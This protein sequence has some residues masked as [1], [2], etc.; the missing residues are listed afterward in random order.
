MNVVTFRLHDSEVLDVIDS[1]DAYSRIWMGQFD[2][3]D[4]TLRMW[5]FTTCAQDRESRACEELLMGMRALFLP[6]AAVLGRGA[7]LGIWSDEVNELAVCAY[8]MQQVIRHDWSW[9]NKPEGDWMSRW[10]D[11][12]FLH[13]SLPV[14]STKCCTDEDGSSAMQL[15]I[16]ASSLRLLLDALLAYD[17]LFNLR[18]VAMMQLYTRDDRVLAIAQMV[19]DILHEE[20]VLVHEGFDE[21]RKRLGLLVAKTADLAMCDIGEGYR[22]LAFERADGGEPLTYGDRRSARLA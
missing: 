3:L 18:I 5:R 17:H 19:E 1:L 4:L 12:P 22:S 10:F 11:E 6:E 8:D 2:H 16:E 15:S 14:P 9:F 7:S 20:S 21:R 13:G